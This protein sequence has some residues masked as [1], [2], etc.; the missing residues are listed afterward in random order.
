M[1][2]IIC[3]WDCHTQNSRV[4]WLR[5]CQRHPKNVRHF[6]AVDMPSAMCFA[7]WLIHVSARNGKGPPNNIARM[8]SRTIQMKD[9]LIVADQSTPAPAA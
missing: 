3:I 1:A 9:G 8:A 6:R 4:E 5:S 2:C 7:V